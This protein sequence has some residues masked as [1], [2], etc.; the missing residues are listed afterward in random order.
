MLDV[1]GRRYALPKLPTVVVCVDGCEP[2]YLAQAVAFGH[3]PWM[4][5]TL[6]TG[7]NDQIVR[8]WDLTNSDAEPAVLTGHTDGIAALSF[9]P[10]GQSLLSASFDSASTR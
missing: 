9:S 10:D 6:A 8:L 3:M 5:R 7:S 2:D 4:K 1:N